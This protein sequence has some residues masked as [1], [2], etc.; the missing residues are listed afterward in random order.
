M[1]AANILFLIRNQRVMGSIPILMEK[2][3]SSSSVGRALQ[4]KAH[5]VNKGEAEKGFVV[6]LPKPETLRPRKRATPKCVR[7]CTL[8]GEDLVKLD[9]AARTNG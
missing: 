6:C 8:L 3:L 1:R 2:S 7:H 5:L 9:I 4:H